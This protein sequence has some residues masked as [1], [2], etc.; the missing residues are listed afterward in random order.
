M[1][2]DIRYLQKTGTEAVTNIFTNFINSISNR[3][4]VFW[5]KKS[6]EDDIYID[7]FSKEFESF[8]AEQTEILSKIDTDKIRFEGTIND[9]SMILGTVRLQF[10]KPNNSLYISGNTTNLEYIISNGTIVNEDKMLAYKNYAHKCKLALNSDGSIFYESKGRFIPCTLK[11][12]SFILSKNYLLYLFIKEYLLYFSFPL[13]KDLIRNIE[14]RLKDNSEKLPYAVKSIESNYTINELRNYYSLQNLIMGH[15]KKAKNIPKSI[16]KL[17]FAQGTARALA[18]QY[19]EENYAQEIYKASLLIDE[20]GYMEAEELLAKYI[21][22]KVNLKETE[23]YNKDDFYY[24][25][26]DYIRMSKEINQKV[27]INFTSVNRLFELHNKVAVEW[28]SKKKHCNRKR[29]I[30]KTVKGKENPLYPLIKQLPEEFRVI[31]SDKELKDEG[32]YMQHCVF[33]Y[34]DV[35]I[36]GNCLIAHLDYRGEHSTVEIRYKRSRKVKPKY[37]CVQA[38]RRFNKPVSNEALEYINKTIENINKA[39]TK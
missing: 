16:N 30:T 36:K 1:L 4:Y 2:K 7:M 6:D 18:A 33:T 25:V 27:K 17:S 23:E 15:Y 8:F 31:N 35:I 3:D 26:R 24:E 10:Y 21:V 38:R 9:S 32:L 12:L 13:Y 19:I 20:S 5:V 34:R 28:T 39:E 14:E 37:Y 29:L 22:S 11:I